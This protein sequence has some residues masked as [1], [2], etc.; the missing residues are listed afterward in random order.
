MSQ[1]AR[2]R[3]QMEK[4]RELSE[5]FLQ[6]FE[7]PEQWTHQVD[8]TA[9]HALWF[10][11]H[12]GI[13]DN[14][15]ISTLDPDKAQDAAGFSEV[16]GMGSQPTSDIEAY[17]PVEEVLAYMRDRRQVFLKILS[18]MSDEDLA[19]PTP[20]GAPDMWP[21]MASIFE[22]AIWHEAMHAGQVSVARRSLGNQ[23]LYGSQPAEA[24]A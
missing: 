21:D 5:G 7:T 2:S 20:E 18:G 3:T 15:F 23:P 16:F 1:S 8:P 6:S 12:M 14:F 19:Q 10:A 24:E 4:V 11:G 17:P 22:M 13:A 9:N